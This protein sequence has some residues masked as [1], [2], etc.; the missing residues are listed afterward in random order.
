MDY[1]LYVK[2]KYLKIALKGKP[3]P[4]SEEWESVIVG[5]Q[6]IY[7]ISLSMQTQTARLIDK[8]SDEFNE[9]FSNGKII[10]LNSD[11]LKYVSLCLRVQNLMLETRSY[12]T[13]LLPK[14][15]PIILINKEKIDEGVYKYYIGNKALIIKYTEELSNLIEAMKNSLYVCFP[16]EQEKVEILKNELTETFNNTKEDIN[17]ITEKYTTALSLQK[18]LV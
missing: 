14:F 18:F 4:F 11:N 5:V 10:E 1:E 9:K 8:I 2:Q 12:L 16:A 15:D 7:A 17:T 3:L 6:C 13:L